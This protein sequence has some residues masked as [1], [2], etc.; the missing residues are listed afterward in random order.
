LTNVL[1]RPFKEVKRRTK[2]V[3]VI[4][5]ETSART[6]VTK[7]M[8][9][10]SEEWALKRHLTMKALEAV[11]KPNPQTQDVER[12]S[13]GEAIKACIFHNFTVECI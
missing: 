3:G 12:R 1:E 11:E 9:K 13:K 6:L 8:L 2:V 4:P 5:N 7:I 10:S